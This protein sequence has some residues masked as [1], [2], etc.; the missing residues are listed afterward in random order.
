MDVTG[1]MIPTGIIISK[2]FDLSFSLRTC[3]SC[4][5]LTLLLG[6]QWVVLAG[7]GD[8]VDVLKLFSGR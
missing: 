6:F 7:V 5:A 4:V 2:F 1:T 3:G 8:G